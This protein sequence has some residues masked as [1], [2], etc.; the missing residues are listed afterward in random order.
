ME[1]LKYRKDCKENVPGRGKMAYSKALG[2]NH[3]KVTVARRLWQ[4][5]DCGRRYYWRGMHLGTWGLKGHHKEL[6]FYSK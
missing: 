2:R 3:K 6:G 5:G 1:G 4:K